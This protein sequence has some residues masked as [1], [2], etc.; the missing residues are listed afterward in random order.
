MARPIPEEYKEYLKVIVVQMFVCKLASKF[1]IYYFEDIS[2]PRFYVNVLLILSG[3]E[4]SN[5]TFLRAM[6]SICYSKIPNAREPTGGNDDMSA[7]IYEFIVFEN[8]K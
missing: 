3:C 7:N 8:D 6:L 4:T 5:C 2:I 1:E